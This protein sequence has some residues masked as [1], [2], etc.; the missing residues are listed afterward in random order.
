MGAE[1]I[2]TGPLF[3]GRAQPM[4]NGM[5]D[6]VKNEVGDA[7]L[8]RWQMNMI[9]TFRESTGRYESHAHKVTRDRDVVVNDGWGDTNDL[10]YGPWLEGVGSRNSPVTRFPG[11]LNLRR[12]LQYVWPRVASIAQPVVDTWMERLNG[13]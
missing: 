9:G 7:A 13:D 4:V 11:Y 10:P 1:V 5:L 8:W 12:A 3:D 2:A 6:E